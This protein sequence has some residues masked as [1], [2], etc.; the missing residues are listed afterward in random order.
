MMAATIMVEAPAMVVEGTQAP[1]AGVN[2]G[3]SGADQLRAGA[4]DPAG[5]DR[6]VGGRGSVDGSGHR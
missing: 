2:S 3:R 5:D 1:A 6:G 4:G